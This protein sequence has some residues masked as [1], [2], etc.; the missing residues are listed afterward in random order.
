MGLNP[1]G[2]HTGRDLVLGGWRKLCVPLSVLFSP[3]P[4]GVFCE[5]RIRPAQPER[6]T[7][8]EWCWEKG[9]LGANL[10]LSLFAYLTPPPQKKK[11]ILDRQGA[12]FLKH[13]GVLGLRREP[14]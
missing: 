10:T 6:A 3:L 12:F 8:T 9:I 2:R 11:T 14:H 4:Q 1:A 7:H 13:S 5:G